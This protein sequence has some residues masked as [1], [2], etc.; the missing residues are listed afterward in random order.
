MLWGVRNGLNEQQ[1]QYEFKMNVKFHT[2]DV[3]H[4]IKIPLLLC[5]IGHVPLPGCLTSAMLAG[6]PLGSVDQACSAI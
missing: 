5:L 4:N 1:E 6:D 3:S 2:K